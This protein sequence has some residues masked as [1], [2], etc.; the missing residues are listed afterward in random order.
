MKIAFDIDGVLA[1]SEV[2]IRKHILKETGYDLRSDTIRKFNFTVPGSTVEETYWLI[3]DGV[4]YYTDE[5]QP[6]S[7]AVD[8][9]CKVY[10]FHKRQRPI[11]FITARPEKYLG[12]ETMI[13]LKKQF[14]NMWFN[15][16]FAE[17][18]IKSVDGFECIVEDRLKN[19]NDLAKYLSVVY[20]VNQPWN[21]D[22]ET[23]WNVIRVN[24]V[25]EAVDKY[26]GSKQPDYSRYDE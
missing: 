11:T 21:E 17:D 2:T 20:L 8:S 5:I 24:S 7:G 19:A 26:I 15:L 14:P 9:I 22:R 12:K 1:D 4:K 6:H 10:E 3:Q 23:E 25:S 16:H 18:K 13:W